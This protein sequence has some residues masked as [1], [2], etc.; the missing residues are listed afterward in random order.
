M[1]SMTG[2]G[3]A[4]GLVVGMDMTV[5]L[6]SLNHRYR[7]LRLLVPHNWLALEVPIE[8]FLRQRIERGRV[9]C[10]VRFG[11]GE[12][13]G[14][15]RL[16]MTRARQYLSIYQTLA[17]EVGFSG[18]PDPAWLLAAE[19]VVTVQN[20]PDDFGQAQADLEKLLSAAFGALDR[21]REGEGAKVRDELLKRLVNVED[22]AAQ[23]HQALPVESQ[24]LAARTAER[25]R[26]LAGE[27]DVS[28]ER[29]AVELAV[30]AERTDVTEELMRFQSHR[31]QFAKLL[32]Q[33]GAVGRELDFLL[34]ELN[35]EVNTLS[36]KIR[37]APLVRLAV[38]LKS[39]LE[40]MREQVQNVE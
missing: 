3:R 21:M 7:D 37:S 19:G 28:E 32:D 31:E 5:E 4:V 26:A 38:A 9:E 35:R 8:A 1:K 18:P 29:L 6:R 14:E 23:L 2:F 30:L 39:E 33:S 22:I 34:Q 13:Q 10:V 15:P 17:T 16:D 20:L 11:K 25:I 36:A 24:A 12:T 27:A 40:K